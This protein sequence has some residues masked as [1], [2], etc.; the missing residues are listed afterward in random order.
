MNLPTFAMTE[1]KISNAARVGIERPSSFNFPEL[2]T[3]EKKLQMLLFARENISELFSQATIYDID[4]MHLLD[5]QETCKM[6]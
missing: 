6:R 3:D 1:E 5:D 4:L 2:D